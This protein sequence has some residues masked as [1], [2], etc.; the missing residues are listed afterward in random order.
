MVHKYNLL[1]KT[2]YKSNHTLGFPIEMLWLFQVPLLIHSKGIFG[3]EPH[4][5]GQLWVFNYGDPKIKSADALQ[6]IEL[7][8]FPGGDDFHP[9]GIDYHEPSSTLFAL[10]HR[11]NGTQIEMFT[12][13]LTSDHPTATYKGMIRHSQLHAPNSVAVLGEQELYVS[14]DH[15]FLASD[16]PWVAA[17][18]TYLGTPSGS[19]VYVNLLT[20]IIRVV[21]RVPFANGVTVLNSTTLAVSSTTSAAVYLYDRNTATGELSNRRAIKLPFLP[22]NLSV[23]R[24]G[25]LLIAGHPHP[26]SLDEF[27]PT[28]ALCRSEKGKTADICNKAVS[29]S[30]VSEWTEAGGVKDIYVGTEYPTSATALRDVRKR[31]GLIAGLYADGI[32]VWKY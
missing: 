29:P 31:T 11:S 15:Y 25:A 10:N 18:E 7:V 2:S 28:R 1:S 3:P 8:G 21:A 19:I 27:V 22:D 24:D 32:L 14:N 23:D 20:P 13:S 6:E 30:W 12:L 4:H 26:P 9:L 16:W 5:V 17:A